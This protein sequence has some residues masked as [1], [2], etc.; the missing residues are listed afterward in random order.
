MIYVPITTPQHTARMTLVNC[1]QAHP[2]NSSEELDAK[3]KGSE[4]KA[5]NEAE[6]G[7]SNGDKQN[8]HKSLYLPIVR[9]LTTN[10]KNKLQKS[11]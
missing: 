1:R 6:A 4:N 2:K 10:S 3:K 11:S 7:E 9:R 5:W 8:Y